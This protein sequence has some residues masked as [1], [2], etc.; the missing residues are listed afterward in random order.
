MDKK[1]Q[2]DIEEVL[3][4]IRPFTKRKDSRV[5]FDGDLVPMNSNRYLMFAIKG[6][7]CVKCGVTADHFK[8]VWGN[9]QDNPHF[10]PFGVDEEG[11]EFMMTRDHIIPKTV[12]KDNSVENSQPMCSSCNEEKDA[13]FDD[14]LKELAEK[15]FQ[16]PIEHIDIDELIDIVYDEMNPIDV[17]EF[18]EQLNQK[19]TVH[20]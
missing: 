1:I 3:S 14:K 2:Y 15:R 12:W 18:V 20:D 17:Y 16:K 11:N 5:N 19:E 13:D 4:T 8:K 9:P 6:L 10:T 7:T